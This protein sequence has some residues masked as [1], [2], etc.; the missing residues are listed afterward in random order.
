MISGLSGKIIKKEVSFID[1]LTPGGVVYRVFISVN[2]YSLIKS[3]EVL[4]HTTHIVREDGQFLYGFMD[5]NEQ[6]M[7][8]M[9]LKVNGVGPKVAMAICSTFSPGVFAQIIE[10][11]DIATL[12]R[13]PG[14]G[15]KG[16]G[17]ILVQLGGFAVDMDDR[18]PA[19]KAYEEA[20]MALESLGFKKE[21]VQKTLAQCKANDTETLV[22]EALRYFQK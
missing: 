2:C 12:K 15:P 8:G 10:N 19:S 7:F 3:D 4:I 16:A 21:A 13:V 22:K 11:K 20:S 14:I 1:L 5:V 18:T 9:L 17:V 6:K